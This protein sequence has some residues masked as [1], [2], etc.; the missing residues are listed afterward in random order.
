M[1]RALLII[2]VFT[3]AAAGFCALNHAANRGAQRLQAEQLILQ[4]ETQLLAQAQNEVETATARVRDLKEDSE[5]SS[6]ATLT[7]PV[8]IDLLLA[9]NLNGQP[10]DAQRRLLAELG[11]DET[12]T[13]NYAIVSKSVLPDYYIAPL[14]RDR[15]AWQLTPELRGVLAITPEEEKSVQTA[16]ETRFQK[17]S[18]WAHENVQREVGKNDTLVS[19]TIPSDAEMEKSLRGEL[20]ATV[21]GAIGQQRADLLQNFCQKYQVFE[22]DRGGPNASKLSIWKVPGA[23][24]LY[25]TFG[26]MSPGS[27]ELGIRNA[28]P[29]YTNYFPLPFHYVFPGGWEEIAQREGLQLRGA[30]N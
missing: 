27:A 6:A 14:K 30:A 9:K 5:Q 1:K 12:S 20:L 23:A 18:S 19:Y 3:F 8:L 11:V 28:T 21:A 17:L 10:A 7:D 29:I 25:Y 26:P 4:E 15:R 24:S 2:M 13:R 22:Q 16:F